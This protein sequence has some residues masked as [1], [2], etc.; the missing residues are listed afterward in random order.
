MPATTD[1]AIRRVAED[2]GMPSIWII[3]AAAVGAI[4]VRLMIPVVAAFFG[5]GKRS[6]AHR[7][8][9]HLTT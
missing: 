7:R 4:N 8:S 3:I 1:E 6:V 2:V 9:R 5:I